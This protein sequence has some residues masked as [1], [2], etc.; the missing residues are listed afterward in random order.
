M[1]FCVSTGVGRWTNLS[2]LEPDAD[3]SPDAGTEKFESRQS[4]ESRSNRHLT[5]NRLQVTECTAERYC[6]LYVVV[7]GPGRFPG[8]LYDVRLRSYGASK[9]PNFQI[10][11]YFPIRNPW[12]VPC[13]DQPTAQGLHRRMITIL[14]RVS[15]LRRDIDIA[16]FC[17]SVCLSVRP[18]RSRYQMK[19]A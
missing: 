18:W 13:G 5:Q 11:A 8:F 14:S 15:I 9:L 1:K 10:F 12:N 6:L 16:L 17:P 4:V 2:T 19:T 3:H 7:Q